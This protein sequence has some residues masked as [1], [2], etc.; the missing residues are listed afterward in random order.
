MTTLLYIALGIFYLTLITIILIHI[1]RR[2]DNP[3]SYQWLA[4]G[5]ITKVLAGM[6]YGY[7][8]AH[9]FEI[10]DSWMLYNES[11]K[12]YQY[13]LHNPSAFFS[14]DLQFNNMT[15]V[16]SNADNATW[17]NFDD[18]LFIKLLGILNILSGGNYYLTVVLFNFFPTLGLYYLYVTVQKSLASHKLLTFLLIFLLPSCLFWN[19]GIHKDGLIV[20]F[21]GALIYCICRSIYYR[22]NWKLTTVAIICFAFIFLF[23]N[24]TALLLVPGITAWIWSVSLGRKHYISYLVLYTVFFCLFFVSSLLSPKFNLPL[25]LSEKQHEFL[26]LKGNSLLPLTPLEPTVKSFVSVFPEA[27]NHVFLRPYPTEVTGIFQLMSF[28]ENIFT[29]SILIIAIWKF[30]S[31]LS[32][33]LLHPFAIFLIALALSGLLLTGYIIPFTG[34]IVRYKSYYMVLLL[35]PFLSAIRKVS[36]GSLPSH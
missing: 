7:A 25:K 3:I 9:Y 14:T 21:S 34:A 23:R 20:F 33:A 30:R 16:F 6:A 36:S 17:K 29:F 11:L 15:D 28:L 10:S 13:L 31:N 26:A 2:N 4:A 27:V 8:Y 19:S 32:T 12:E 22:P 5:Y 35:L 24:V 1:N 18:N